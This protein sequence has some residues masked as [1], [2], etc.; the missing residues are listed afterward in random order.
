VAAGFLG[1]LDV[2]AADEPKD[3]E[4]AQRL[5][6]MIRKI[7]EFAL[8]TEK[9][10]DQRLVRLKE[11][12]ARYTNPV[13]N[14]FTH[15]ALFLWT[16]DARPVA[17][18]TVWIGGEGDVHR[19]FVTL[20]DQPLKCERNGKAVWTPRADGFVRKPLPEGPKPAGTAALRLVQLRRQAERFTAD[21]EIRSVKGKEDLRLM[22]Q[23]LYRYTAD[24]GAIE[25][26]IFALVHNSDP[27]L[28]V[29]LELVDPAGDKPAWSY[30]PARMSSARM[31]LRLDGKEVWERDYYWGN[32]RAPTDPYMEAR[33]GT[34][35]EAEKPKP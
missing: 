20:T 28:L 5:A 1:G 26:A 16:V 9:E 32:P 35:P 21:F 18:G 27:E 29:V 6:F 24:K 23:P 3:A 12:V 17:G 8:A 22:P 25:G 7:D 15:G 10:P 31:R 11:P 34:Y 4:A 30:A 2:R 14:A 33:D 13:R 19:E